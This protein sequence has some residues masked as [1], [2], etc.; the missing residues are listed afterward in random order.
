MSP[1]RKFNMVKISPKIKYIN[2]VMKGFQELQ[3][4]EEDKLENEASETKIS[5]L[6]FP[7]EFYER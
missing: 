7:S 6:Q 4:I 3:V 2:S 5:K 1:V